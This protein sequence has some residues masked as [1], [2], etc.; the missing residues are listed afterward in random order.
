[1][2]FVFLIAGPFV[3]D[4][5]IGCIFSAVVLYYGFLATFIWMNV[6]ALDT[7]W[8][9]R[10][11]AAFVP[12][13]DRNQSLWKH[14]LI[15]WG[16]PL[17]CVAITIGVDHSNAKMTFRPDFG[18]L[19]C[20]FTQRIALLTY[21]GLP[22]G[23]SIMLNICFYILTSWNLHKA[24]KDKISR[25]TNQNEHHFLVYVR[26]FILMG[27]TWIFGFL[28]A[29]LEEVAIDF[30]FVIL[31]SLQGVFLFISFVCNKRVLS[32]LKKKM[33]IGKTFNDK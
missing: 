13:G 25:K 2:A 12:S 23:I 22:I 29:F 7:W 20:W 33:K 21:F 3:P 10:P 27:F 4:T 16:F 32:E 14:T 9:F 26:L 28:S 24:F 18:G 31:T 5:K 1:M 17:V 6:I 30:I 8:T 15:G 19:R 11:S